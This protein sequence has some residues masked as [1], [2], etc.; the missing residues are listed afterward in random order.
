M[1]P[2]T[3]FSSVQSLSRI[4][5]FATTWTTAHQASLSFT[6]SQSLLKLMSIEWVM[7]SNHLILCHPLLLLP[8]IF[9]SIGVFSHESLF[10]SGG[11]QKVLSKGDEWI[12]NDIQLPCLS[13]DVQALRALLPMTSEECRSVSEMPSS[14]QGCLLGWSWRYKDILLL[15]HLL[16][17]SLSL[18]LGKVLCKMG[19]RFPFFASSLGHWE[20]SVCGEMMWRDF[21]K[22]VCTCAGGFHFYKVHELV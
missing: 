10:T 22:P 5:L 14:P 18:C 11:T 19:M 21:V 13:Q 16:W 20:D 3:Q 12:D 1:V 7:P 6:V 15:H 8:S 4:R 2:G 17:K 9:P